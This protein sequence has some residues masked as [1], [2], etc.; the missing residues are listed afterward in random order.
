MER[1]CVLTKDSD[2]IVLYIKIKTHPSLSHKILIMWSAMK[3]NTLN[4]THQQ[5]NIFQTLLKVEI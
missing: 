2:K 4:F 5:I 1:N 3:T